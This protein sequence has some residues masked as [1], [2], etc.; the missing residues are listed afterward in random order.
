MAP[1]QPS[2][3]VNAERA[4]ARLTGAVAPSASKEEMESA[5]ASAFKDVPGYGGAY[6]ESVML[7]GVWY[8]LVGN[9]GAANASF[10]G[11]MPKTES[12]ATMAALGGPIVTAAQPQASVTGYRAQLAPLPSVAKAAYAP[13][14]QAQMRTLALPELI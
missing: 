5:I 8:D 6:K 9:Y 4:Y 13:L 3:G 1:A 2:S 12:P 7:D 14:A 10:H 11:L